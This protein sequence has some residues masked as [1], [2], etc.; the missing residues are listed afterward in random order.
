M[1]IIVA[2]ASFAVMVLIA[3]ALPAQTTP[4]PKKL[5]LDVCHFKPG[6]AGYTA[7]SKA[8]AR[9]LANQDKYGVSSIKYWVDETGGY[10][11]SL[12]YAPDAEALQHSR[13]AAH[14]LSP[15][16]IYL[17]TDGA[18]SVEKPGMDYYLDVHKLGAG[19]VTAAAVADAHKKDLATEG[20]YNVNFLNYWVNEKEGVVVCLSQAPDSSAVINTHRE[21]HGLI[22]VYIA[23][24]KQGD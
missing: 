14:G 13:T 6:K 2:L 17:V 4:A 1:K 19:N 11:Y 21:A 24:V 16:N 7:V 18:K 12:S 3:P 22:P 10:V 15:D 5:Y 8:H 9:V 23:K 20:K